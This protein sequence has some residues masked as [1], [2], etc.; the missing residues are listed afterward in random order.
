[1]YQ[2]TIERS[3]LRILAEGGTRAGLIVAGV[4]G[5]FDAAGLTYPETG[6]ESRRSF[7]LEAASAVELILAV[8]R[9]AATSAQSNQE[10]YGEISF[11]LITDKKAV[12][13]FIGRPSVAPVALPS[14]HGID[15]EVVKNDAAMWQATIALG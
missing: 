7:E 1:M 4:K 14:V 8:L 9:L 2:Y 5:L 11:S 13:I 6:E 15:G 3:P 10:I 12:G